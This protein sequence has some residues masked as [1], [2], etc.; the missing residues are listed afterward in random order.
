[1]TM[2]GGIAIALIAAVIASLLFTHAA[3]QFSHQLR[4]HDVA[5]AGDRESLFHAER[6]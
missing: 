4:G 1:M 5:A 2:R 3:R 6:Y